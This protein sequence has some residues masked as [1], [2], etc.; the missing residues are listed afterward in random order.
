MGTD[1]IAAASEGRNLHAHL[2]IPSII[3]AC[4]R[5]S[6]DVWLM[7]DATGYCAQCEARYDVAVSVH[8]TPRCSTPTPT[9]RTP[10]RCS[11]CGS[12]THN[13]RACR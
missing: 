12:L 8:L 13:V 6:G 11:R 10:Q 3:A 1:A 5:C 9:V 2:A 4:P 7:R